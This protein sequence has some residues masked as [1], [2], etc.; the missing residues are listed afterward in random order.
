[1]GASSSQRCLHMPLYAHMYCT[2]TLHTR[3]KRR[4]QTIH[5]THVRNNHAP[6]QPLYARTICIMH[7]LMCM[8]VCVYVCVCVC[9]S[10]LFICA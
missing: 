7:A 10:K 4:T 8:C 5:Y 3:K 2:T 1:M 9:T 6:H